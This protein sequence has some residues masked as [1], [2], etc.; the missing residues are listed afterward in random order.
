MDTL[1]VNIFVHIKKVDIFRGELTD[2]QVSRENSDSAT[3]P[4][5]FRR[6][7]R[8]RRLNC[9]SMTIRDNS[10]TCNTP[11]LDPSYRGLPVPV[12]FFSKF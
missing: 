4:M 2:I 12:R 9:V 1:I 8:A 11:D 7:N 10:D 6:Q 3:T 5:L